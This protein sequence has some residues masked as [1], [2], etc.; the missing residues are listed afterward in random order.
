[1]RLGENTSCG[2]RMTAIHMIEWIFAGDIPHDEN[3]LNSRWTHVGIGV[4]NT[5]VSLVFG[6]NKQ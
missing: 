1:M 2:Y 5:C 4:N 6:N 3:Q